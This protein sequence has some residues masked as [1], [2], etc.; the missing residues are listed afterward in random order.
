V[1]D[2]ETMQW[3]VVLEGGRQAH[4]TPT[5]HLVYEQ[6]RT[7]A[8]M[9]TA[10][11]LERLQ[12]SGHPVSILDGVRH[13]TL[14]AVDYHLSAQ[15]TLIYV[16]AEG[17]LDQTLVWVDRQGEEALVAET[18]R[19]FNWPR[20]SPDGQ[21]LA[22]TIFDTQHFGVWIYE[23]A[24]GILSPFPLESEHRAAVWAPDGK[25]FIFASHVPSVNAFNI[26]WIPVDASV[27]A[28]QL[29]QSG[30]IQTPSS[31][32]PSAKVLA[33]TAGG[34]DTGLDI[35]ELPLEGERRAQSLLSTQFNEKY[36]TFSPDGQWLA[37][38]SDRSGRDEVYV[39]PY[40]GEGGIVPISTDGGIQP[41][42]ARSGRELFY[43]S[44]DK[45]MVVPL[46][47]K[48]TLKAETPRV[49]FE[50]SYSVGYLDHTP[51]Y[52]VSP[53]GQRFVMVKE[54]EGERQTQ[55][56]IILNWFEELK[57]LVPTDN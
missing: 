56:H 15:G 51:N 33:F 16:P 26:F 46:T 21:R 13:N 1:L 55:I 25:R 38:T 53:D 41:V 5:G 19:G 23:I 12:V 35:W 57:R 22:V 31:W 10:F 28:E 29:T 4:Y 6:G 3:N 48:P 47:A 44:G 34:S 42:W 49:L 9:A 39:Q 14:V 45:M 43:R 7:G 50:G 24:R 8:I 52:D 2:L 40:P 18:K 36:P 30:N 17:S 27:E 11:D 32:H 37:F 20:L 54:G